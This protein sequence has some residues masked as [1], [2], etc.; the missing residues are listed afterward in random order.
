MYISTFQD[1]HYFNFSDEFLVRLM[2][3][4]VEH[5]MSD[6]PLVFVT[7]ALSKIP[8][9]PVVAGKFLAIVR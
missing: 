1:H 9:Q 5:K 7:Y 3:A 4:I 8:S 6:I 2:E